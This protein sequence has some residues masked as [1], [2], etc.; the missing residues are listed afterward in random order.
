MEPGRG[1][2]DRRESRGFSTDENGTQR[3]AFTSMRVKTRAW[4]QEKIVAIPGVEMH[5]DAVGNLW[6]TPRGESEREPLTGGHMDSMPSG[7][8]PDGCRNALAG[9]EILRRMQTEFAGRPPVK[10]RVVDRAVEEGAR[11]AKSPYGAS[12]CAGNLDM[13]KLLPR[14]YAEAASERVA[15]EGNVSVAW[16]RWWHIAPRPFHPGLITLCD[17]TIGETCGTSHRLS[18]GPWHDAA[19]ICGAG[20]PTVMWFGQ[21]LDGIS[22]NQIED[23]REEHLELSVRASDRPAT[24]LIAGRN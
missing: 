7:G 4:L 8:R 17:E 20:V 9:V 16:E 1:V 23:T 14:M 13:E 18:S 2:A 22:H 5:T 24:A 21:S 6:A 10:V 12:A 19:E 11:F 3:V 15:R